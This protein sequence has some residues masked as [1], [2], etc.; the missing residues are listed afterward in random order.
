VGGPI[1]RVPANRFAEALGR[2]LE[3][4]AGAKHESQVEIGFLNAGLG[5]LDRLAKGFLGFDRIGLAW[6]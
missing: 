3:A 5:T 1:L 6:P 4:F 2:L